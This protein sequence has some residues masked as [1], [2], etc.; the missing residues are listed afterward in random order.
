MRAH[1]GV[2]AAEKEEGGEEEKEEKKEEDEKKNSD[3]HSSGQRSTF[4][5]ISPFGVFKLIAF[6][7]KIDQTSSLSNLLL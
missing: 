4:R 5:S 2:S 3:P 7:F 6:F 1:V